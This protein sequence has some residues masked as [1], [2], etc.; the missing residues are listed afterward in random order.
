MAAT[1]TPTGAIGAGKE[2]VMDFTTITH[3]SLPAGTITSEGEIVQR[4]LTAYEMTD[5]R[6]VGFAK[7]HGPYGWVEPLVTFAGVA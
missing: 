3:G 2:S 7:V 4:T 5:G 6:F 1:T